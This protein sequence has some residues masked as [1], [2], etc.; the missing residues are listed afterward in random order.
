[1]KN[2][3]LIAIDLDGTLLKEDCTISERTQQAL[4]KVME[5]GHMVV[6]TTGR[7]YRNTR[8]VLRNFPVMPYYINANGTVIT[9]GEPERMLFSRTIPYEKGCAIYRLAME[10]PTFIELYS[11][12][13]AYDSIEGCKNMERSGGMREYREQLLQTN[14]HMESLDDFVIKECHPINKFHIVCVSLKDKEELMRRIG[15]LPGVYPISTAE[16]NIEVAD[17]RWSKK[18]G[19]I[20]LCER[21]GIEKSQV[22]A[23]GDSDNDYEGICWA[24]TGIAM[25]N[26]TRRVREAADYVTGSNED[27]GVA[28][29]IEKFGL[30]Q[31][32]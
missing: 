30:D 22:I 9:Q 21:I 27:D 16:K 18:D 15:E 6:P 12:M 2:R 23:I 14:I 20:W 32:K 11:G 8:F 17:T 4:L 3:K 25:K 10:Y 24:G 31:G 1:M 13:D 19:M 7:G 5:Q 26:A 29:V 28:E